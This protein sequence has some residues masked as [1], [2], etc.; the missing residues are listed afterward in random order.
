[1]IRSYLLLL[2]CV[3]LWGSNFVFGS[4][5]VKEFPPLFL[6]D[7]RLLFTSLFLVLY[8]WV[9]RKFVK[10]KLRELGL[11]VLL[12]LVGT[13]ANQTAYFNG[14][15]TTDAT[16]ASLILSLAPIVTAVLASMFLKEQFTLRMKIGSGIALL[17][18]FFVVGIGAGLSISKGVLLIVIAMVTFSASMIIIRK[19]TQTM[20]PFIT[21]VYSTTVGTLFL[22]PAALLTLDSSAHISHEAWAWGMLIVTAILMQGVCGIVWNSQLQIVGTG[23][24]AIFLNLQPFVAMLVGFLLLG[25]QVTAIQAGGSL[26]IVAGVVVA[27]MRKKQSVQTAAAQRMA[28]GPNR[29]N[30]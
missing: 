8:A 5:L 19:L 23:K 22:T 13:L 16:T 14:L 24:A 18:T 29:C 15:L 12:G 11:L 28:D 10:I 4:M 2:F 20:Q 6:A 26:L 9:T 17:G 21:T 25:S 1:M 3:T 7:V 30:V 27:S